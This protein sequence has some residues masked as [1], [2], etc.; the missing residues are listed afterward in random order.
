MPGQ[1][2]LHHAM[3]MLVVMAT[4][5]GDTRMIRTV[6]RLPKHT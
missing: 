1:E 4:M 2:A 6:L 5:T 3:A